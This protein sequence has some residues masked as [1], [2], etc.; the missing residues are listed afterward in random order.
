MKKAL[1]CGAIGCGSLIALSLLISV[2]S[3]VKTRLN[4]PE[5]EDKKAEREAAE[6]RKAAETRATALARLQAASANFEAPGPGSKE[7]RCAVHVGGSTLRMTAA[8]LAQFGPNGVTPNA[9]MSDQPFRGSEIHA[10]ANGTSDAVQASDGLNRTQFLLVY[11]PLRY[12]API[13]HEEKKTF[14][15]G[16]F[17]GFLVVMDAARGERVCQ[18]RFKAENSEKVGGGVRLKVV[19]VPVTGRASLGQQVADDFR[20]NLYEA[21]G[22]ALA[23]INAPQ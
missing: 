23:R 14:E 19:G 11:V 12:A 9:D 15:S 16:F 6:E 20:E 13:L 21:A 22:K 2:G 5:P 18:T 7:V 1:G 3:F 4:P 10:I 8:E 17:D